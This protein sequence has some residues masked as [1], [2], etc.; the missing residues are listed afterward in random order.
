MPS[1][2]EILANSILNAVLRGVT[3]V[4]PTALWVGLFTTMPT[5]VSPGIE[6]MTAGATLYNRIRVI[7]NAPVGGSSA[8]TFAL[9]FPTAGAPWGIITSAGL[10]DT[11][12]PGT[13]TCQYF[14]PLAVS[15]LVG[16]GGTVR[17]DV[18]A[19]VVSEV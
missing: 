3:Y 15:G 13:G 4:P 16:A 7:F 12:T 17:F 18:G 14:G 6:V 11:D 10:F 8:N 2:N 9:S 5:A 19:L 1:K